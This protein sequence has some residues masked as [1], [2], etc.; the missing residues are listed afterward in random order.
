MW[1]IVEE[2]GWEDAYRGIESSMCN[3]KGYA[4]GWRPDKVLMPK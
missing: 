4:T 2:A 1:S 3:R